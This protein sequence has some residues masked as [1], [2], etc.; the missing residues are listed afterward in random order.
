[1]LFQDFL[2]ELPLGVENIKFIFFRIA[3]D[4]V[5]IWENIKI[6]SRPEEVIFCFGG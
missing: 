2:Y 5:I 4:D 3:Q 1:V 6:K